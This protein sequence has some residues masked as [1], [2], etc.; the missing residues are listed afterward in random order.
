M[1]ENEV[2][3]QL[4]V[5][6]PDGVI[7]V[8]M[9]NGSG[10]PGPQAHPGVQLSHTRSKSAPVPYSKVGD[11]EMIDKERTNAYLMIQKVGKYRRTRQTEE[12]TRKK[13]KRKILFTEQVI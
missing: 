13:Y 9:E 1:E 5:D 4:G 10:H 8:V 12:K 11:L 6:E 7:A 3:Y 2:F